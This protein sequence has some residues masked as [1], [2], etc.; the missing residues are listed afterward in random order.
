MKK[1]SAPVS[2]YRYHRLNISQKLKRIFIPSP[3]E[4]S[5][6]PDYRPFIFFASLN[7]PLNPISWLQVDFPKPSLFMLDAGGFHQKIIWVCI[8]TMTMKMIDETAIG[9]TLVRSFDA[10]V[11]PRLAQLTGHPRHLHRKYRARGRRGELN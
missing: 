10:R 1:S 6:I 4:Y 2:P 5:I 3:D 8:A 9:N 11:I 7:V